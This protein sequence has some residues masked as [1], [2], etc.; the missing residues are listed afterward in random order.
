MSASDAEDR[1][2]SATSPAPDVP[3]G[4]SGAPGAGESTGWVPALVR[5]LRP[6]ASEPG[7]LRLPQPPAFHG[8]P[9]LVTV[10]VLVGLVLVRAWRTEGL[11]EENLFNSWLYFA[12]LVVGFWLVFGVAGHFAFSQAAFAGLGAYTATWMTGNDHPF[13]LAVVVAVVVCVLVALAFGLLVRRAEH[14]YFA[15]ATL[16][17]SEVLLLVFHRWKGFTDGGEITNI[18]PVS[19]FGWEV[20]GPDRDQRAF[21][22]LLGLLGLLLLLGNLLERSPVVREATAARDRPLVAASAGLPVSWIR[23]SLLVTGSAMAGLAGAVLVHW[24]G[25]VVTEQFGIDLGLAIFLMLILGGMGSKYGALLGAWFYVYVENG[26]RDVDERLEFLQD[27][28]LQRVFSFSEKLDQY[29]PIVYGSLLVIVM[30]ALPDGLIGIGTRLSSRLPTPWR[31]SAREPALAFATAPPGGAAGPAPGMDATSVSDTAVADERPAGSADWSTPATTTD[32]AAGPVPGL[33]AGLDDPAAVDGDAAAAGERSVGGVG[34]SARAATTE[35][36]AGLALGLGSGAEDAGVG[37]SAPAVTN[38]ADDVVAGPVVRATGVRVSFGGVRAVDEVD[39][40]VGPG[41]ILGLIGPN[42]SGKSTL[43]NALTGVVPAG[44]TLE[45]GGRRVP[46]GRPQRSRRAGL[47]RTYQ[48]PQTFTALTCLENVLLGTPRRRR[49][50]VAAGILARPLVVADERARWAAAQAAL[51]EVGLPTH[52]ERPAAG[53]THR[54][55]RL[56]E[57]ARALV[58]QPRALLLDEPSAG[59]NATE[60]AELRELLLRL[61]DQGM[62]LLV[63]DH[64]ID[65]IT[66]LCDRV[67]VLELGHLV[68]EGDPHEIWNDQRVVDVYLGV[69]ATTAE[70]SDAA[71]MPD[72]PVAGDASGVAGAAE[73]GAG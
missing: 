42:G 12:C 10:G 61:R 44:G 2:P 53:L 41:E 34:R 25:S 35:G 4:S 58:G 56:L 18:S 57:L 22:L 1:P 16:G 21:W 15:I 60:T 29:W 64:K 70:A 66:A 39:V 28:S 3:T 63:V 7:D 47:A 11:L 20:S 43:L 5:R 49:T 33:D 48:T 71:E 72:P 54:D 31:R 40:E 24:R 69:P 38:G 6:G 62:S 13:E 23:T 32:G 9:Y 26:L 19:L 59:L 8:H 67:V 51:V 30:I 37:R 52:A 17:L 73:T 45:V 14:L 27:G 65:F 55:Q 36:V 68:A 50:G 46:L